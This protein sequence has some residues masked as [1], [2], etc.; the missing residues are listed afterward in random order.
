MTDTETAYR[1]TADEIRTIVERIERLDQEK[2]DIAETVKEVF[3]EAKGRGYSTAILRK[4]IARRKK[5]ADELAEET[6]LL[7]MYENALEGK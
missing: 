4:V 5:E 1:V 3:A 2:A 6:A 7:E